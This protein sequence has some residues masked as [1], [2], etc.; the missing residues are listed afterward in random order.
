[1]ARGRAG[2]IIGRMLTMPMRKKCTLAAS[3]AYFKAKASNPRWAWSARS[4]DGKTVV[5]TL[6]ED[7]IIQRGRHVIYTSPSKTRS[8]SNGFNDRPKN[9]IWALE[10]CD[11]NFKSSSLGGSTQ[12]HRRSPR[13]VPNLG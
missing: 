7:K 3:F 11:G 2:A 12:S 13:A 5:V 8:N 9:L 6:W 10:N 1:M 4:R